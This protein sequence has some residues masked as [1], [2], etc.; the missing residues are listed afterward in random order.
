MPT[1]YRV[2]LRLASPLATPLHS[3]TLFGNLCWAWR[4]LRGEADLA[5][6]LTSLPEDPFLISDGFPADQLPRP[7]LKPAAPRRLPPE[8]VG[9]RKEVRKLPFIP[10]DLFLELRQRLTQEELDTRLDELLRRRREEDGRRTPAERTRAGAETVVRIPHNRIHR[11]TGRTPDSGGLFFVEELWTSGLASYRDVYVQTSLP[12]E[13]LIE[14]FKTVGRWGYGRD[15]TWGRGR[16]DDR[17]D[18]E[19]D[20][21][22]LFEDGFPRLMSLSHGSLSGNMSNARY[23][24]DTLI[25]RVGGTLAVST[26]PFKYPMLLTRPGATFDAANGP[27]GE[28]LL[29]VHPFIPWVRQ[30]AWHL[31]VGFQEVD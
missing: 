9:R 14:L 18:I 26:S 2:R 5:R 21:S 25:G 22:G 13:R 20:T 4:L 29:N 31:T 28:L 27:F 6:W 11:I 30:N 7:L 3:G 24:I 23:R 17:I 10:K 8:S 19:P 15:A 16:F 12:A 1:T